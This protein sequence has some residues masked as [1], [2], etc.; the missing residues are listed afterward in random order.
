ML[1]TQFL[2]FRCFPNTWP[3]Y[4]GVITPF[5]IIYTL[6]VV[7]FLIIVSIALHRKDRNQNISN[8]RKNVRKA[9]IVFILALMFGIGWAFGILGSEGRNALSIVFQFLFIIIVG[10]QGLLIFLLYPCRSKDACNLW[11]KWFNCAICYLHDEQ[12]KSSTQKFH[13]Q[14]TPHS[15]FALESSITVESTMKEKLPLPE[16]PGLTISRRFQNV[17]QESDIDQAQK[18]NAPDG[19]KISLDGY[20]DCDKRESL[21]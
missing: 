4:F 5:A 6:N 17:L 13:R 9:F 19:T 21:H 18:C 3:L 16:K 1:F 2:W 15:A 10:C 7:V 11:K 14:L 8:T 20:H 12:S